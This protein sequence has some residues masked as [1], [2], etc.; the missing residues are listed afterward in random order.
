MNALCVVSYGINSKEMFKNYF[1]TFGAQ[2]I[3]LIL[4]IPFEIYADELPSNIKMF[5][6]ISNVDK[7]KKQTEIIGADNKTHYLIEIA[8]NVSVL[9]DVGIK[10]EN[11]PSNIKENKSDIVKSVETAKI[12]ENSKENKANVVKIIETK[13]YNKRD[14]YTTNING[15]NKTSIEAASNFNK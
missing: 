4:L 13:Q 7:N 14:M 10:K 2:I 11:I 9:S 1:I 12:N 3:L 5:D 6:N 15:W 8:P